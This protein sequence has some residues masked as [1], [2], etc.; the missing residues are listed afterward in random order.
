MIFMATVLGLALGPFTIGRLSD[1]FVASGA[2]PANGLRLGMLV[3]LGMT[4]VG[5]ALIWLARNA[6]EQDIAHKVE[7]ARAAGET[8]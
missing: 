6:F 3:C 4:V 5:F 2:T 1:A 8:I 7:R